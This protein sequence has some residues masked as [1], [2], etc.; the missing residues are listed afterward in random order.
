MLYTYIYYLVRKKCC[1]SPCKLILAWVKKKL[2]LYLGTCA[3]TPNYYI[4][5]YLFIIYIISKENVSL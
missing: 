4:N 2:F 1:T 3:N 5:I